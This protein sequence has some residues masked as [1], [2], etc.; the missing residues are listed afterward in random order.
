MIHFSE[1]DQRQGA[2]KSFWSLLS[3]RRFLFFKEA[4]LC[5]AFSQSTCFVGRFLL[6][7]GIVVFLVG[8]FDFGALTPGKSKTPAHLGN[9]TAM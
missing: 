5:R 4:E 1:L 9:A 3:P 6:G 2:G 7:S 8:E